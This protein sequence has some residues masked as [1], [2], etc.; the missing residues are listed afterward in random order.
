MCESMALKWPDPRP[1]TQDV[2]APEAET[3]CSSAA[4]DFWMNMLRFPVSRFKATRIYQS[5]DQPTITTV[6]NVPNTFPVELIFTQKGRWGLKRVFPSRWFGT[7]A[8]PFLRWFPIFTLSNHLLF[9]T[10]VH[11]GVFVTARLCD[12]TIH[13]ATIFFT[14]GVTRHKARVSMLYSREMLPS[15]PR[16]RQRRP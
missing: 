6:P 5:D 10:G 16:R 15:S 1:V 11:S 8:F 3:R 12:A 13:K 7:D 9:G 4:R 14:K 2:E